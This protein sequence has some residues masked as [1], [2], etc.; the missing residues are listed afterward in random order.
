MDS[1]YLFSVTTNKGVVKIYGCWDKDTPE[2]KCDFY[3]LYLKGDCINE[4][5]P[6]YHMPTIDEVCDFVEFI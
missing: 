2:G 6:Y 3:D 5:D 1:E 4:G